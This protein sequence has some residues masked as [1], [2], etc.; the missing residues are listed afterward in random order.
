MHLVVSIVVLPL[1][2]AASS[3]PASFDP[4]TV[5]PARWSGAA[6]RALSLSEEG[7]WSAVLKQLPESPTESRER[8][9]RLEALVLSGRHAEAL[10]SLDALAGR[11]PG[12]A[13]RLGCL[14]AKAAM[15]LADWPMA[16][17]YLRDC[18][19]ELS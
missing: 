18:F 8:Y 16:D 1:L 7:E 15:A 6:A 11:A 10:V 5:R 13:P 17:R 12:L 3:S 19:E 9:L 4:A 2:A 14:G